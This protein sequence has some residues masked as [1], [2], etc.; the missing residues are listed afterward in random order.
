MRSIRE[1]VVHAILF[2]IIA[3]VIVTPAAMLLTGAPLVSAGALS[4]AISLGAMVSNYLWTWLF[5]TFVPSRRRGIFL[6]VVQAVGLEAIIAAFSIPLIMA[7]TGVP[8]WQAAV[9]DVGAIGFFI[10]FT[11]IY[12]VVFDAIML[13]VLATAAVSS[14][15]GSPS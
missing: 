3:N 15:G 9:L 4:L 13:R 7:F 11:M 6:R 10:V 5:D 14:S 1:R 2:E 12:N 8:F